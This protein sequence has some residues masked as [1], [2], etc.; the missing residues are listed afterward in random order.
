MRAV[1]QDYQEPVALQPAQEPIVAVVVP[2]YNEESVLEHTHKALNHKLASLI[3]SR[4]ISAQSF[5][6]YVD[7]GSMDKTW[8]ILCALVDSSKLE[9]SDTFNQ[10]SSALARDDLPPPPPLLS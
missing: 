9:S 5:I 6:C 4:S 2:C 10:G 3:D 7:D 1:P 8:K